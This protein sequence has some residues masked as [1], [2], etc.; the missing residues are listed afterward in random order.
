VEWLEAK[1]ILNFVEHDY[2]SHLD[3]VAK[4]HGLQ[5]AEMYI[6]KIPESF[7]G[8]IIYRTFLASCVSALN[9]KKAEEV[10]NTIRDIGLP[11]TT[12]SCDQL[13]LLYKRVDRKKVSDVLSMMEKESIKPSIFTYKLLID[14]KGRSYDIAGM[15]QIVEKMKVEGMWPDLRIQSMVV[16]FYI[17]GGLNKKAEAALKEIEGGDIKENRD[18]CEVLLPLYA[19]LDKAADVG[20]VW[21]VCET[22]PRLG[23]SLAAIEAWGKVGHVEKAEEIFENTLKS[24]KVSSKCYDAML[25]VYAN[26]K[27]LFEGEDLVKRM[28]ESGSRIGPSTCDALVKLYVEAG[29]V[30][31]ADCILLRE[32]GNNNIRPSLRSYITLLKEYSK[33]GDIHNAEKIFH[34]LKKAGFRNRMKLYQLLLE[35]YLNAKSP[36]Y[37]FRERMGADN[38][39][40]NKQLAEQLASVDALWKTQV[41]EL[42]ELDVEVSLICSKQH[43]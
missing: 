19:A 4:V 23:E 10:F 2:A 3:L 41:A 8:E 21:K 38:I 39:F 24:S 35:A 27:L 9:V 11:I 13:L 20:R 32:A 7:K 22:N 5:Q 33:R 37:G 12:F 14:L 25:R 34:K 26:R 16:W 40:P 31:K 30:E 17:F 1:K 36:A 18:A 28:K 29:E 42:E 43:E 15:E 6:H